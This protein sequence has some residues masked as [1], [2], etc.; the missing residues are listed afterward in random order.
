MVF[1]SV[2]DFWGA[3]RLISAIFDVFS[4]NF[5]GTKTNEQNEAKSRLFL[6]EK[7]SSTFVS[8][9]N[10]QFPTI[11]RNLSDVPLSDFLRGRISDHKFSDGSSIRTVSAENLLLFDTCSHQSASCRVWIRL[12]KDPV[13][14]R[15]LRMRYPVFVARGGIPDPGRQ[16]GSQRTPVL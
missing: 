11:R 2:D 10:M 8:Y 3:K 1:D 13:S 4:R 5:S 7:G 15:F 16:T 9:P 12:L 6:L 14:G